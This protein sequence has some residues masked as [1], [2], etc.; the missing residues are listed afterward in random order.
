LESTAG[1]ALIVAVMSLKN[2]LFSWYR[3]R[4]KSHPTE[5]LTELSDLVP[6]MLGTKAD[7]QLKTKAAETFGIL[8]FL[9][10]NMDKFSD[11]LGAD[12]PRYKEAAHLLLRYIR[13]VKSHGVNLPRDIQQDLKI[14][15]LMC[16][17]S[18]HIP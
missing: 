12:A 4:R 6:K 15:E 11:S 13:I 16:F 10:D 18:G 7:P 14:A 17:C 9:D 5:K 1:E 8:V 2:E 3:R